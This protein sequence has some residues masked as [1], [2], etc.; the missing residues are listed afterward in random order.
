MACTKVL[1][2]HLSGFTQK[3]FKKKSS[4]CVRGEFQTRDPQIMKPKLQPPKTGM[5]KMSEPGF[6]ICGL[7]TSRRQ[8]RDRIGGSICRS[9]ARVF[10]CRILQCGKTLCDVK[11]LFMLQ[12]DDYWLQLWLGMVHCL[13]VYGYINFCL[14]QFCPRDTMSKLARKPAL[15]SPPVQDDVTLVQSAYMSLGSCVL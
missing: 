13:L 1:S 2:Q 10:T 12:K 14:F 5:H 11:P 9:P 3:N 8:D 15:W 4:A 6:R 7:K